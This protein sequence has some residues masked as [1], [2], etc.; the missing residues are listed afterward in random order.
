MKN[1]HYFCLWFE[2]GADNTE[3]NIKGCL[4]QLYKT[5]VNK[6]WLNFRYDM[7]LDRIYATWEPRRFK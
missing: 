2:M 1:E 3:Q 4:N 6:F 7:N 5:K